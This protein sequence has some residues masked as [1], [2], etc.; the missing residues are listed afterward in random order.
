MNNNVVGL[1]I[2]KN[3]FH[4]YSQSGGGNVVKKKLKRSELLAFIANL[5]ASL[6]GIEACGGSHYWAR[7]FTKLGHE[8]IS[9]NARFVKPF[10]VGN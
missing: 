5:P 10:V 9:L 1:D 7:E 2:A 3:V 4:L 6:V 8:V